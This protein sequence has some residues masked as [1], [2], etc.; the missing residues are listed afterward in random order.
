MEYNHVNM[1]IITKCVCVCVFLSLYFIEEAN[2]M[3]VKFWIVLWEK[4]FREGSK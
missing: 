1:Y 2:D 3:K 4:F